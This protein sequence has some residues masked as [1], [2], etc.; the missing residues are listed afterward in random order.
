MSWAGIVIVLHDFLVIMA[1]V[2][3][4]SMMRTMSKIML[5]EVL[6]VRPIAF[7]LC[8]LSINHLNKL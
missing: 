3:C 8:S 5:R 4:R 6:V 2:G 1:L 7:Q